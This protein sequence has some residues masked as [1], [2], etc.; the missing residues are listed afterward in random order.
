MR[1]SA[2]VGLLTV[3]AC[4]TTAGGGNVGSAGG[5]DRSGNIKRVIIG[6]AEL[7]ADAQNIGPSSWRDVDA[8]AATTWRYLP[9]AFSRLGLSITRYDSTSHIIEGERLR[10]RADFG[11]KRLVSI[12]NCGDV[13]GMPNVTRFEVNIQVRTVLAGTARRSSIA[14]TVTAAAKPSEV[15]GVLMPC[16]VAPEAADGVAAALTAALRDAK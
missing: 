1:L 15:S 14:S 9:V 16:V 4:A 10:S 2:I 7:G 11:G 12:M 13:A 8:P 6:N 5:G 3:C